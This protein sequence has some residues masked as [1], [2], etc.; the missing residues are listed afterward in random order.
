MTIESLLNAAGIVL[1][2][3]ALVYWVGREHGRAAGIAAYTEQF[4]IEPS[5]GAPRVEAVCWGGPMDGRVMSVEMH[6][7][8]IRVAHDA[9]L[10]VYR[11][12]C[13]EKGNTLRYEGVI[14]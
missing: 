1:I 13:G 4:P 6:R 10:A 14:A 9:G 7:P 11:L 2:P 5:T 12:E 3:C 8:H